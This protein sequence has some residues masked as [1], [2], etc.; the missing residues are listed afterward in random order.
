MKTVLVQVVSFALGGVQVNSVDLA[1]AVRELGY[2]SVLIAPRDTLA[3]GPSLRDLADDR[4]VRL[5]AFERP[6]SIWHGARQLSALANLY[7]ADIVHGYSGW[8]W[9][10]AYWGPCL[11]G[12]RPLVMTNYEM[13]SMLGYRA[14][15]LIVGTGY[16]LDEMRDRRHRVDLISPPVD[17][18]RDNPQVVNG[19][20]LVASLGLDPDRL[21]LVIV[22][23]L[24]EE[25]KAK[26]V[27]TVMRALEQ[28]SRDDLDLIIVGTGSAEWRLRALGDAINTRLGRPAIR[29]TG[30][31]S[32]PRPAYA[33]AD[34]VLG[35]GSSAARG[36]AFAKPLVVVGE[37]G[38][39]SPFNS[40]TASQLYRNSFWSYDNPEQ[41]VACLTEVLA[42]LLRE[43]SSWDDLGRFGR[44]FAEEN[45]GLRAMAAKL[46]AVYDDAQAHHGLRE[47]WSEQGL[48]VAAAARHLPLARRKRSEDDLVEHPQPAP[49]GDRSHAV[50]GAR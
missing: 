45:F 24:D 13:F 1:A 27:E 30:P 16:L 4:G 40:D 49:V 6:T 21:R 10:P 11:F 29:F 8:S 50:G 3:S 26:S 33:A 20:E 5:E 46:A 42:T 12:R 48:E 28:L 39:S 22:S 31:L 41:P 36:L 38:W 7:G 15:N 32:D 35:M 47:W 23:R 2:E 25:M 43:R 18:D 17:L 14:S 44:A 19:S 34:I 9:R 37:R